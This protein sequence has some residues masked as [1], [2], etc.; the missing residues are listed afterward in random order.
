MARIKFKRHSQRRLTNKFRLPT[1]PIPITITITTITTTT[2]TTL[3]LIT[4]T[5]YKL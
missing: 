2:M 4:I 1:R 3:R 5:R